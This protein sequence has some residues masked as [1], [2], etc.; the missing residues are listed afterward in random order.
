L[1]RDEN[2]VSDHCNLITGKYKG[3]DFPVI[4]KQDSGKNF[5]DILDTGWSSFYLISD[6]MKSILEENHL[7]GWKTF[8][9]KLYNKKGV[10]IFGYHGLSITGRCAPTDYRKS[11]IIEKRLV[12]TGPIGKYYKGI[13][14]DEWDGSDF[15]IPEGTTR[16]LVSKKAAE[17][18]K[19]N[20]ITNLY[21]KNISECEMNVNFLRPFQA[22]STTDS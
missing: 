10:E 4:F 12:P 16:P 8:P 19:K 7:T 5:T 22:R 18:L 17:I 1:G 20:K 21:L 9:I 2:G 11:E 13:V 6:R 3:I 14:V 15:F